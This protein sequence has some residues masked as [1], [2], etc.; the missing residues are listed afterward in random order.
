MAT[1]FVVYG[2]YVELCVVY[3]VSLKFMHTIIRI[4]I[5]IVCYTG[6]LFVWIS[7]IRKIKK[8][9]PQITNENK[10]FIFMKTIMTC[11]TFID[12]TF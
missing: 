11:N 12:S 5:G 4:L 2:I 7:I 8:I 1:S 3:D 9:N 6:K 10:W